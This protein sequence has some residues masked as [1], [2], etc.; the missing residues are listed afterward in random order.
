MKIADIKPEVFTMARRAEE[1]CRARFAE[2]DAVAEK[3]TLRVM[4]A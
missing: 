4:E 2:I 1:R 3:N